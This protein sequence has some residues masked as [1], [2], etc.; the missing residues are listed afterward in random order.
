MQT[1]YSY[2]VMGIYNMVELYPNE[3]KG[4]KNGWG[5]A[6]VNSIVLSP[7]RSM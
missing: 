5:T 2:K 6:N 3:S 4:I 1:I 7:H